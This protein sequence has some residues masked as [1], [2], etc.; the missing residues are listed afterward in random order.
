[1]HC[2]PDNSTKLEMTTIVYVTITSALDW[3]PQQKL[4]LYLSVD[5]PFDCG[6]VL[7]ISWSEFSVS[8]YL[9][10]NLSVQSVFK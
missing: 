5:P 1:M 2:C 4:L 7:S 10:Y 3:A 9:I 8:R 6:F